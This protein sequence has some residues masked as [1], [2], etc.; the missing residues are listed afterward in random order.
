MIPGTGGIARY[1][2][3][4]LI[5]AG[6]G[7]KSALASESEASRLSEKG[8]LKL[9]LSF[10]EKMRGSYEDLETGQTVTLSMDESAR[11]EPALSEED[12]LQLMQSFL[13]KMR[14]EYE[15]LEAA[16]EVDPLRDEA[17]F[18]DPAFRDQDYTE[19]RAVLDRDLPSVEGYTDLARAGI[20]EGSD[21]ADLILQ[22]IIDGTALSD[23]FV[24][25]R[26]GVTLIGLDSLFQ[27]IDFPISVLAEEGTASG[28]FLRE[29]NRFEM[30]GHAQMTARVKNYRYTF[31]RENL[32]FEASD[33][34]VPASYL[35]EWFGLDL[36]VEYR[37]QSMS[38]RSD[39]LLPIQ[40][41]LARERSKGRMQIGG[42]PEAELPLR[43]MN[44]ELFGVPF[45]DAQ[46][47]TGYSK[48]EDKSTTDL[49]YSLIGSGDLLKM[50]ADYFVGG[51]DDKALENLRVSLFRESMNGDL[52]GPLRATYFGVGDMTP[53]QVPIARNGG[54]GLGV[55]I[56]NHQLGTTSDRKT[57][58]L[59]GNVQPGWDVELYR[60]EQLIEAITAKENGLYEFEDVP[61]YF[62]ANDFKVV[63]FGPQ[64]QV[65]EVKSSVPLNSAAMSGGGLIYDVSVM[66]PNVDFSSVFEE[67]ENSSDYLQFSSYLE[68]SLTGSAYVSA[69]FSNQQ[70][71]DG[72]SHGFA[73]AGANV[74][75]GKAM[76]SANYVNDIKG[77]N[78]M[79]FD[80]TG[81][82]GK[83]ALRIGYDTFK[84]GFQKNSGDQSRINNV[85]SGGLSGPLLKFKKGG[86]NYGLVGSY[87]QF[88]DDGT[89]AAA[90]FSLGGSYGRWMLSNNVQ[91]MR[92][93]SFGQ[94]TN[95]NVTGSLTA[96][97]NYDRFR[98]RA[99]ATYSLDPEAELT[100]MT[101]DLYWTGWENKAFRVS[102]GYVPLSDKWSASA[103][104]TWNVDRAAIV[105]GVKYNSDGDFEAQLMIRFGFG[106][107]PFN[108]VIRRYDQGIS[109]TGSVAARI[110]EDKDMDG[111]YDEDEPLIEGAEI[112]GIQARRK[113]VSGPSGIAYLTGLR[114]NVQTDIK[115]DDSTLL[116]PFWVSARPGA[117]VNPRAGKMTLMDIPVI[118]STE[119]E[120][121][122]YLKQKSGNLVVG[123]NIPMI[124]KDLTGRVVD[125]VNSTFDGF[126]LFTGVRPGR[127]L[128][129]PDPEYLKSRD[130][131]DVLPLE[132]SVVGDG[133]I[134]SEQDFTALKEGAERFFL[135][136][137][138][139][140]VPV[141]VIH[142]GNY[143]S[144]LS[145]KIIWLN[146]RR[147][148]PAEARHLVPVIPFRTGLIQNRDGTFP[149]ML[150]LQDKDAAGM[151]DLVCKAVEPLTR[152]CVR[153]SVTVP[154]VAP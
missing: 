72:S 139:G 130:I 37:D 64:G 134:L 144:P 14:P 96:S 94:T 31:P 138:V 122:I 143:N 80:A 83:Q 62:G 133:E 152:S 25:Y 46:V 20:P 153:T 118:T 58:T 150:K 102:G 17:L 10:V 84:D 116:D 146:I 68:K 114:R 41:R 22:P 76:L 78:A 11:R 89:Q 106:P 127:Y 97:R 69:G 2:A 51:N 149:L 44:Y 54:S 95:Q 16:P 65:R 36:T 8:R 35:K 105:P 129:L 112:T 79:E 120:G 66:R 13:E 125:T 19:T 48:R 100:G 111:V 128:I 18:T 63:M 103:A 107:D 75:V 117:S 147:A 56:S 87:T 23:I 32:V 136:E 126:Y 6:G 132:I 5:A 93:E 92:L 28:W 74:F 70:F 145:L 42:I 71:D 99:N 88:V 1:L 109:K 86:M 110:F 39:H 73:Y 49:N 27:A 113:A 24:L 26:G 61:L 40:E 124:L 57:T 34:F 108:G 85:Y 33:I 119:V 151:T 47:S 53:Q 137:V 82:L 12:R 55:R 45:V 98:I 141:R 142:L 115:L 3:L 140:G 135:D 38:I 121:T 101:G 50:S 30:S 4:A 148:L 52:L 104:M 90:A 15:N 81:L 7:G 59:R 131:Q 77:G 67:E 123:Q 29:I 91:G 43:I 21:E 60:N 9:A 154:D